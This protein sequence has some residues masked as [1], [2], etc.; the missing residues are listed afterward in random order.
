MSNLPD[1]PN[2][3]RAILGDRLYTVALSNVR[4]A[5]DWEITNAPESVVFYN[6]RARDDQD[7]V[8]AAQ[9]LYNN[10]W[11]PIRHAD[12]IPAVT[13]FRYE[14][15]FDDVV[16]SGLPGDRSGPS[17]LFKIVD[18]ATEADALAEARA[19]LQALY[20]NAIVSSTATVETVLQTAFPD[21]RNALNAALYAYGRLSEFQ[22]LSRP[23]FDLTADDQHLWLHHSGRRRTNAE[24]VDTANWHWVAFGDNVDRHQ[25]ALRQYLDTLTAWQAHPDR[26]IPTARY[27]ID[28]I[29]LGETLDWRWRRVTEH[30]DEIERESLPTLRAIRDHLA[31]HGLWPVD[32]SL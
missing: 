13:L 28:F 18:A 27:S 32:V 3:G 26:A 19:R 16:W 15:Q 9:W 11:G 2:S 7:A 24:I 29:E 14:I 25:V 5:S 6:V 8:Y 23:S 12:V 22:P 1:S 21:Y 20:P 30:R 10:A 4:Q 31:R 17:R